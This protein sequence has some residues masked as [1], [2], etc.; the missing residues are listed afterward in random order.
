MKCIKHDS[1]QN[2]KRIETL[3]IM[4]LSKK[5]CPVSHNY[6]VVEQRA[7]GMFIYT[8]T[9]II[10]NDELNLPLFIAGQTPR[11]L[12]NQVKHDILR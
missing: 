10:S 2:C 3:Q 4:K 12:L 1:E 7:S 8:S 6:Y 11:A 5:T 9:W